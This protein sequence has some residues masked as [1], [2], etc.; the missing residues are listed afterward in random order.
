MIREIITPV[1]ITLIT[2]IALGCQEIS[3]VSTERTKVTVIDTSSFKVRPYVFNSDNQV[4]D[5]SLLYIGAYSDSVYADHK[6]ENAFSVDPFDTLNSFE[7]VIANYGDEIEPYYIDWLYAISYP[8]SAVNPDIGKIIIKID[9]GA[10]VKKHN[11]DSFAYNQAFPVAIENISLDTVNIGY[12]RFILKLSLVAEA[13]DSTGEWKSIEERMPWGSGTGLNSVVLP[14]SGLAISSIPIYNG[15]F[16]TKVRLRMYD[17][18]SNEINSQ[19]D[20]DQILH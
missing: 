6:L 12:H 17:I 9:T 16:K 1:L 2:L 15:D 4:G 18:V 7:H 19:I 8:E 20:Y 11:L 3:N 13:K 5:Y 14:P 10:V